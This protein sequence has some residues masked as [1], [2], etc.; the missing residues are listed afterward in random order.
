[1]F[2]RRNQL[3]PL[4]NDTY[5]R[6]LRAQRPPLPMFLGLSEIEQEALAGIGDDYVSECITVLAETLRGSE[7]NHVPKDD[8]EAAAG[9]LDIAGGI[10]RAAM[11]HRVPVAPKATGF[12]GS[13][14]S[15]KPQHDDGSAARRKIQ[16]EA[17]AQTF[18]QTAQEVSE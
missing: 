12:G 6:W 14:G 5:A 2:G 4:T 17:L 1:M 16:A 8:A 18:G 10:A 7:E 15:A 3:P 13:G 11:Q 9:L